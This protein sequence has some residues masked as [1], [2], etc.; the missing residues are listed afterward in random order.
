MHT[1]KRT[2]G[3]PDVVE[4]VSFLYKVRGANQPSIIRASDGNF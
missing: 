2:E 3:S 4:P 1:S